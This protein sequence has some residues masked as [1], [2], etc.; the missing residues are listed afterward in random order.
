[1]TFQRVACLDDLWSGEMA[2]L[3]VD[4]KAILLVNL[5]DHVYAYADSCPHQNSRLSEGDLMGNT[6]RCARHYWEFE[7]STGQGIN[8]RDACL[9]R[10]PV[11]VQNHEILVDFDV[12][13][14]LVPVEDIGH[15]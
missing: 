3:E 2:G 14:T 13:E 11:S 8:P 7:A 15:G 12:P 5:D 6:L 9:R 10:F 4:G 1:M